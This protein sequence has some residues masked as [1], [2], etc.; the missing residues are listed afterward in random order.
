[1]GALSIVYWIGMSGTTMDIAQ[2]ALAAIP[3]DGDCSLAHFWGPTPYVPAVVAI[4]DMAFRMY[5]DAASESVP[6]QPV[7][8][9]EN[10]TSGVMPTAAVGMFS[11]NSHA[12][13]A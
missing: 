10:G 2:A 6:E 12:H 8:K 1:L 11:T 3:S 9:Q 5:G 7:E 13:E 4:G